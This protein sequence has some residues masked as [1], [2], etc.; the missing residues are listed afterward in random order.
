MAKVVLDLLGWVSSGRVL[1]V[2]LFFERKLF[3]AIVLRVLLLQ[4]HNWAFI[5]YEIFISQKLCS[6]AS[7]LCRQ[8]VL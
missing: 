5:H 7:N 1:I 3:G 2:A 4:N 6:E 8:L